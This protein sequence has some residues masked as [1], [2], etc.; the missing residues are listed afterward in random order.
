[1]LSV[2]PMLPL[3]IGVWYINGSFAPPL[4]SSNRGDNVR[5][6]LSILGSHWDTLAFF[7]FPLW[8]FVR[9][10]YARAAVGIAAWIAIAYQI[11]A[12]PEVLENDQT[13]FGFISAVILVLLLHV[14]AGGYGQRW[15]VYK[16]RRSIAAA[17]RL[18]ILEPRQRADF[19]RR[20]GTRDPTPWMA[21]L[22][23][24]S[25]RRTSARSQFGLAPWWKW[26]ALLA[27]TSA[28]V[29]IIDLLLFH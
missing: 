6:K 26:A 19:L 17:N 18:Q 29:R 4:F 23:Q 27:A 24:A 20:R 7:L 15:V 5:A 3:L 11:Y 16:L 22:R 9:G 10:L 28:I 25:R 12:Y 21:G 14:A 13:D 8:A 2:I 1:L